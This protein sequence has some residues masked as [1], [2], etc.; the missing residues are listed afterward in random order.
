MNRA[1]AFEIMDDV[2]RKVTKFSLW[3]GVIVMAWGCVGTRYLEKDQKLLYK[4]SIKAPRGFDR[5]GMGDIYVQKANRRLFSLPINS[6][7]WMYYWG[8]KNFNK[9]TSWPIRSKNDF[10]RKKEKVEKKFDAKLAAATRQRKVSTLQFR[11][12]QKIDA[13]N[14]QIENGNNPMQWGEKVSVY[15]TSN[16]KATVERLNNYLFNHG[17]F[18]GK[19][20][21]ETSEYK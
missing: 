13:L 11:K 19:T 6:L 1:L 8:L 14:L 10:I 16:V 9:E 15:D 4:Q 5:E 17:Y 20:H 21:T 2:V 12:A 18:E 3:L 7:T